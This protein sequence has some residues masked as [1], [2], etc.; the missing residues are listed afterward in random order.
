MTDD[1]KLTHI[2]DQH[3]DLVYELAKFMFEFLDR[4][5]ITYWAIGGT[6]IGTLRNHPPGPIRWDD[7]IDI[8]ILDMDHEKLLDA[9]EYD[10]EFHNLVEMAPHDFG[11]QFRLKHDTF[12]Y[13]E[14]YLDIFVYKK[15]MGKNGVKYYSGLD[16]PTWE[17][18]YY[19]NINEILPVR[20]HRFWDFGIYVP[21]DLRTVHRGYGMNV[22]K[23]AT[24]YNHADGDGS[25]SDLTL[26]INSCSLV[27]MLSKK[28]SRKLEFRH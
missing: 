20:K 11:Y 4:Y 7:D 21:R 16:G 10:D 25:T 28:L 8:G 24:V 1:E 26:D 9:M 5:D 18:F 22:I 13:K 14:F 17:D 27:P 12:G 2:P 6:L 23:F 19:N 3:V 15:Q